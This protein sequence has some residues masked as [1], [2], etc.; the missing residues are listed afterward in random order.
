MSG[1][2]TMVISLITWF[3][4]AGWLMSKEQGGLGKRNPNS[5]A[6]EYFK[7]QLIFFFIIH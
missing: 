3:M 2:I 5:V 7:L 4:F 6:A 1:A